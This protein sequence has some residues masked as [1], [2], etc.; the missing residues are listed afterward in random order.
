[1]ILTLEAR[2][3]RGVFGT[4]ALALAVLALVMPTGWY[5]TLPRD[6]AFARP[7]IS[8][9]TLLRTLLMVQAIV[10][11]VLAVRNRQF[12]RVPAAGLLPSVCNSEQDGDLTARQATWGLLLLTL[13]AI[14]LRVYGAGSDLWLDEIWTTVDARK[15]SALELI[16]SFASSNNHLLNSLLLR[17]C[18]LAFGESEWS[19]RVP[20]IFFGVATVPLLYWC[21]RLVL[22]RRSALA[23]AALLAVSYHHIFFSQNAR[24]YSA[25]ICFAL[26]ATR[27]LIDGLQNDRVSSWM[28]YIAAMFLGFASLLNTAFVLAAH[29]VVVLGALWDVRRRGMPTAPL[30]RRLRVV[31]AIAAFLSTELYA[32]AL[33]EVFV[34]ITNVY[35][36]GSTGFAFF[37]TEFVRE[38]VRGLSVGFGGGTLVAAGFFLAVAAFGFL[39]LLRR[40]WALAVALA[41][42]G[43]I[44]AMFL[45][46]RHLTFS[47]RYF[48]LWL[49]LTVITAVVFLEDIANVLWH[50]KPMVQRRFVT[51]FALTLAL[52]SV[53]SLRRYYTVPKQPYR[54]SLAYVEQHRAAGDMVI[55]AGF[56]ELGVRYYG[57]RADVPLGTNY[58]FVRSVS[59]LD[60]ALVEAGN[61]HVWLLTTLERNMKIDSP[62]LEARIRREYVEVAR[63]DGTIGDGGIGVWQ[64]KH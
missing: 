32:V 3:R 30:A 29:G 24:G 58:R 44:T 59:K 36:A 52:L 1:M 51:G 14:A 23:A 46:V 41:L 35:R 50:Q 20:A 13:L 2:R 56:T 40:S 9:V 10:L 55:A 54:T 16:C 57:E 47:P 34:V 8:G 38:M 39:Q 60:S 7:S 48:L 26:L 5:Y 43:V 15:H 18:I 22:S 27:A 12:T 17:A 31:F 49:P 33:P 62:A 64:L 42:P 61:G 53:A 45:L 37:S 28:L 6:A 25:Y 19:V 4:A 11:A 63:F 21:A